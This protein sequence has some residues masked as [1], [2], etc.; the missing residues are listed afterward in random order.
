M[1]TRGNG[2]LQRHDFVVLSCGLSVD[3]ILGCVAV[4]CVV[5]PFSYRRCKWISLAAVT[6][7]VAIEAFARTGIGEFEFRRTHPPLFSINS[8]DNFNYYYTG[9]N[10]YIHLYWASLTNFFLSIT[11]TIFEWFSRAVCEGFFNNEKSNEKKKIGPYSCTRLFCKQTTFQG[12][13]FVFRART[14]CSYLAV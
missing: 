4:H 5:I 8:R 2:D 11:I 9:G 3:I 10:W 7:L 1:G 14:Y 6:G 12:I 13:N